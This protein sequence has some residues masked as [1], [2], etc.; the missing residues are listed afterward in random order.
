MAL[1]FSPAVSHHLM[2]TRCPSRKNFNT[3][4]GWKLEIK[5]YG[6]FWS[7]LAK[8]TIQIESDRKETPRIYKLP[9][10][11]ETTTKRQ[12]YA[13]KLALIRCCVRRKPESI[14]PFLLTQ[15][16][17]SD[18]EHEK[19]YMAIRLSARHLHLSQVSFSNHYKV[20]LIATEQQF[21]CCVGGPTL[22]SAHHHLIWYS[23][24]IA[25]SLSLCSNPPPPP[26][27]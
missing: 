1:S 10:E 4:P 7:Y 3:S 11:V 5:T 26:P 14:L 23:L 9:Q 27:S 25:S 15:T 2:I 22:T 24:L 19:W 12:A 21:S 18:Y 8:L 6:I 20:S 16:Y 13:G 17:S